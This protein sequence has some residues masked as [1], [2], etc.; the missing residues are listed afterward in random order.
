MRVTEDP[1]PATHEPR[2]LGWRRP[3]YLASLSSLLASCAAPS[4]SEVGAPQFSERQLH[5]GDRARSYRLFLPEDRSEPRPLVVFLHGAGERGSDNQKQLLYLPRLLASVARQREEPCFILAPQCP[6]GE[7]W[8]EVPWGDA[9]STPMPREPS[10]AMKDAI[11]ALEQSLR[12]E[13]V[14]KERVYLIGL[15]MGGFGAIELAQRMPERFAAMAAICGGGDERAAS[16]LVHLPC[17]FVHGE[18]D[19]VVPVQRSRSMVRALRKLGASPRYLEIPGAGHGV[20]MRAFRSSDLLRWLFRKR[21]GQLRR[22]QTRVSAA[23]VK[24]RAFKRC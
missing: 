9:R 12:D 19:P 1:L 8:A 17:Y 4:G 16:R 7:R 2:R 15:S 18:K 24:P 6:A 5:R 10:E 21:R 11:A 13:N 14:D 22:G 23:Q 20:W 3:L